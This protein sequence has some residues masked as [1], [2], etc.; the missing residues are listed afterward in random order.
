MR[1]RVK[2]VP[3]FGIL[4]VLGRVTLRGRI[5]DVMNESES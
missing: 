2:Y 1:A 3:G 5:F 4:R